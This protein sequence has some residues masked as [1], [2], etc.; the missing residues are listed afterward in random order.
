MNDIGQRLLNETNLLFEDK[1][2]FFK[3]FI[4]S[5]SELLTWDDVEHCLNN[6]YLFDFEMI[7]SYNQ[8]IDIPMHRTAWIWNKQVQD[9][10]FMF[11]KFHEGHTLIIMNYGFYSKKT[12]ELCKIFENMYQVNAAIHVYCGLND[13]KSFTIHDDY[14]CNFIVQIEGE[15]RWKVFNNRISYMYK[16]GTMNGKLNE[17][18][19]DL[20]IDVV[21]Q[22]GDALYI[23]SRTYHC[24]YPEGKRLSLSI[25]CWNR[26]SNDHPKNQV[27]R[28]FYKINQNV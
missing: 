7:D 6:P 25:P 5:P 11:S 20:A 28:N 16:T 24:A 8:K 2:H 23:P 4:K 22:P 17:T 21:L 10:Q 15:T 13:A 1:P 26:F 12:M 27:D 19:L 14:P 18:D 3:N 9:K